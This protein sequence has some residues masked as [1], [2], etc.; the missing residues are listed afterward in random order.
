MSTAPI[1]STAARHSSESNEHYTPSM[2]VE[3][4]RIALGAIDLD[5]ASCAVANERVRA[6][7]FF[8]YGDNGYRQ[9]WFGRV[10]LNPPG[11]MSD[12]KERPVK[13]K[14]RETGSCGLPLPH[15]HEGVEASAKK[16]WF[17]LSR[18]FA[19]GRVSSAV[20]VGFSVEIL[21][22]T[23]VDTPAGL[24]VPLDFAM[25]FP[26]KRVAYMRPDGA[27]GTQPPHASVI[28]C[29]TRDAVVRSRFESAFSTMGRVVVPVGAS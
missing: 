14:C 10:F 4:A 23:Q 29:V 9:P 19:A 5:P 24:A 27:A 16:W 20:F 12:N 6:D 8:S 13:Q 26:A 21:Q 18:E 1:L 15:A 28:V 22:N 11:G 17:K 7:R 25:A 3:A 2:V